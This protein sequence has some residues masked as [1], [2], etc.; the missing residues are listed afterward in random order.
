[1]Q[2]N[3]PSLAPR[4][5]RPPPN[6]SSHAPHDSGDVTRR[7]L[8]GSGGGC[9]SDGKQLVSTDNT[10]QSRM[11]KSSMVRDAPLRRASVA[12]LRSHNRIAKR[13]LLLRFAP[14]T[15]LHARSL[16]GSSR[17]ASIRDGAP[18]IDRA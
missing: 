15:A 18:V 6:S 10:G 17:S 1:M 9:R 11:S 7:T 4:C 16:P 2:R 12:R 8:R 3:R 14:G 13:F 5:A